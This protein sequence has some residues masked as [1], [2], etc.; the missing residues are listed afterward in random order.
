[1]ISLN[2]L[3]SDLSKAVEYAVEVALR[4]G[5]GQAEAFASRNVVTT[6]RFACGEQVEAKRVDD[7][8]IGVRV[9]VGDSVGFSSNSSLSFSSIDSVVERALKIARLKKGDPFFKSFVQSGGKTVLQNPCD[10]SLRNAGLEELTELGAKPLSAALEKDSSLEVSGVTNFVVEDC[11]IKNS[12]GVFGE[13][14][15]SFMYSQVTAEGRDGGKEFSGVGWSTARFIKDFNPGKA[16]EEAALHALNSRG[17]ILIEPGNYE[18]VLGN[19]AVADVCEH[20]LSWA[21]SLGS[22][23]SG[24]SFFGKTGEEVASP[25]VSV[26][27]DGT[28]EKGVASKQFDDEGTATK[29]NVL[30]EKGVLKKFIS[31]SYYANKHSLE[32]TGNGFR[33]S[34]IPGRRYDAQ[35]SVFPTNFSILPG[36]QENLVKEIKKGIYLGRT[37]YTYPINPI[38]GDFTTTN[39]SNAFLIEDGEI[40][41]PIAANSFRIN[42]NLPRLLKKITG[43]GKEVKETVVWGGVSS[44]IVPEIRI[45]G[46]NVIYSKQDFMQTQ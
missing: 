4:R 32:S 31:D 36:S 8:G 38:Q 16:G 17:G 33:F 3:S 20:V 37:W 27:D 21:L 39:R 40:T 10:E 42:D 24:M 41:K 19:Y 22:I 29:K 1:M 34:A 12:L 23:D 30:I 7:C 35:P 2:E 6:I 11:A 25:L 13:D 15:S 28:L 14:S 5:A 18:V 9:S 26:I 44:I 45:E 46:V 43:V